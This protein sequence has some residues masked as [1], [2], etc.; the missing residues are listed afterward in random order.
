MPKKKKAAGCSVRPVKSVPRSGDA[1]APAGA[2]KAATE[3]TRLLE[4]DH[5]FSPSFFRTHLATFVRDRCPD[6]AEK[7]PAVKIHLG[8]GSIL[9]VCHVMGLTAA[10]VVLAVDDREVAGAPS[11]RTEIVPFR[12]IMRV[13]I[14][15]IPGDG[16]H[17]GFTP[18]VPRV[19]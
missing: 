11:M 3:L 9:D 10:Y 13:T 5:P 18:D 19:V 16:E 7:L 15:S 8:D 14:R 1:A 4:S 6:P 12:Q 2:A 17:V